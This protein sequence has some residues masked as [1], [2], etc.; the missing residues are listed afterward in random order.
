[1]ARWWVERYDPEKHANK[2]KGV[3]DGVYTYSF[4]ESP[5]DNLIDKDVIFV[6]VAG[7]TFQFLAL[8]HLELA[9][10]YFSQPRKG[11]SRIEGG[12][13]GADHWEVQRWFERLPKGIERKERRAEVAKALM[14]A[15]EEFSK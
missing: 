12:I 14:Q 4:D 6:H 8:R 7:F 13:D 5:A 1:M 2:M 9:A 11:S 15:F 10:E 3:V